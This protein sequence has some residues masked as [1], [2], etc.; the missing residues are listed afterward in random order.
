[1]R[2]LDL[3]KNK[4]HGNIRTVKQLKRY[5]ELPKK[6]EKDIQEVINIHPMLV[7][8]YYLSLIDKN[9]KNDPI[10][11]MII[12]SH[13]EIYKEGL[14]DTSGESENTKLTGLQ[15]KYSQTA[16][17]L[18]TNRCA[19]YCRHCFRKRLVG[20]P[21]SEILHRFSL[22]VDYIKKHKEINNVLISGGDPFMLP[23]DIIEKFLRLLTPIKHLDFIRFGTRTPITYPQRILKDPKLGRLLKKYS[24]HGRR[25]YVVTHY[26]HPNEI[27]PQSE[28]AIKML[29][30]ANV[31]IYNQTVLLKGVNDNPKIL[32]KLLNNLIKMDILPYYIFQ[33]RPVKRVKHHFQVPLYRGWKIFE[34]T[35]KNIGGHIICKRLKYIMAHRTGK[36]EIL[37]V[38]RNRMYFKYHHAKNIK[39]AGKLF[40]R[41]LNKKIGWLYE[42]E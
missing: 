39:N 13:N 34:E 28:K 12:P 11:K 17:I 8:K 19:A 23:T 22:A 9:D 32:V 38:H 16:L 2:T 35:K 20:L 3:K 30:K 27:T 18:A 42:H 33:C 26:N 36:I 15:H 1:M 6:E 14:Y 24:I 10:K 29:L 41:K 7:S 31:H 40:S 25:I 4:S 37:G 21:S 5:L